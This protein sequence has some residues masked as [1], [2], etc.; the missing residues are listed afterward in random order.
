MF[1]FPPFASRSAG[2]GILPGGLPHSDIRGSLGICPSPRLFA[3]CHVL[4][5]LREPRHP[6]CA[7][8][9]FRF[10]GMPDDILL[11]RAKPAPP[12]PFAYRHPCGRRRSLFLVEFLR[13]SSRFAIAHAAQ[14]LSLPSCQCALF[15]V[16]NNG[17]EPLTLC[18]QSRCSNQLS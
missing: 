5:R 9:S 6:P 10:N 11:A 16:E 2:C 17:V 12:K 4:L 15:K 1:Q 7:L 18:L 8:R 13:L 14:S 3:T